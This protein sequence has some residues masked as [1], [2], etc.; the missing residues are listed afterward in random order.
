MRYS[1]AR[2]YGE[3]LN[4]GYITGT[5]AGLESEQWVRSA[6]E[7]C[8]DQILILNENYLQRVLKAYAQY[9][10]YAQPHQGIGQ[11][12]PVSVE[13]TPSYSYGNEL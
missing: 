6:R 1:L 11:R 7:E 4:L 13:I 12:F 9:Y 8:L 10:Y 3:L 5:A 2:F